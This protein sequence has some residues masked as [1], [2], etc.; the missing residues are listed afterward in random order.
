MAK[1]PVAGNILPGETP[2]IASWSARWINRCGIRLRL[3]NS[4]SCK[5]LGS[6][7][8][9]MIV[10][11]PWPHSI[12]IRRRVA[13]AVTKISLISG[14]VATKRMT[15]AWGIISTRDGSAATQAKKVP[16][17]KIMPNSPTKLGA[18]MVITI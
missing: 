3:A 15:A 6:S 17:P 11:P 16:W 5:A 8:R 18:E 9:P 14:I 1:V 7:S 13:K 4:S 2:A 10:N 12:K